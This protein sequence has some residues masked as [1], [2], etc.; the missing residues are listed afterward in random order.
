MHR[1]KQGWVLAVLVVLLTV[2]A[3]AIWFAPGL[4]PTKGPGPDF[5]RTV[6]PHLNH[7][8][9]FTEPFE[10][11][12]QVT[13]ACL[14]CHPD[15]A[16]EVMKTSH[17]NWLGDEVE[18]PGREGKMRI[19]KKNLFNNFC[20][21]IRGNWAS[22][23][24]CHAG[25]GWKDASFD[26]DD[27]HKVDCL[28]CH[29]GTGGYVKG[30][31]GMPKPG[32]DLLAVA[33]GV[34]WPTRRNCGVCHSFGGGGLGVK[35][36]DMDDTLDNP[37]EEDDVHMGR[38]GLTCIDCHK[39]ERHR[40]RGRSMSL[41]VDAINSVGCTDCHTKA[42]H[43]DERLNTHLR[44]VSCET[45]HIPNYARRVATKM[46]WDWSKAGNDNR[47]ED[48]HHYM[49]IK[50]EFSYD[51]DVVPT[52]LWWNKTNERYL[53]GDKIDPD[54]ET[55]LNAP[56][57]DI[58]DPEAKIYPFKLHKGRHPYDLEHKTFLQPVTSGEGGYWREF[59]WDKALRLGSEF[60][61][62][63]YSGKYGFADSVMYWPLSHMV[64]E[65]RRALNCNDCHGAG[66]RMDWKALGYSEDPIL[67][68]GR[69]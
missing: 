30:Q 57:G 41:G 59:D 4:P 2:A 36:G 13:A 54:K 50:G 29:D 46:W 19:G 64:V 38:A 53:L 60:V 14:E 6:R 21:G 44:S 56:G 37:K 26:F 47:E 45:C 17:W 16:S 22:C 33:K 35:H 24:S 67:S 52:Y 34:G 15:A 12:E 27:K 3:Y 5:T 7:S 8:A 42:P 51:Q 31:A 1:L 61:G 58:M 49:K 66:G 63:Q 25:Y 23:T 39:T 28:V 62:I 55:A 69:P 68:G 40:I 32:V 9:F 10:S 48:P 43:V 18:I 65:K 20:L 11:P